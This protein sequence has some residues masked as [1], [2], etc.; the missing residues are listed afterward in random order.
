M[1]PVTDAGLVRERPLKL[2]WVG[3]GVVAFR[4]LRLCSR[5][6]RRR[7][8]GDTSVLSAWAIARAMLMHASLRYRFRGFPLVLLGRAIVFLRIAVRS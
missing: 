4:A 2:D 8:K 5:S 1:P 6:T 3:H 7:K